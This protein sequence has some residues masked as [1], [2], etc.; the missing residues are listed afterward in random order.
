MLK[1]VC[2]NEALVSSHPFFGTPS[3]DLKSGFLHP[4]PLLATRAAGTTGATSST[5]LRAAHH[6]VVLDGLVGALNMGLE[7]A[8]A[9]ADANAES[10]R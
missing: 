5:L 10:A 1:Q 4:G 7:R 6:V 3:R 8:K 9:V 2:Q